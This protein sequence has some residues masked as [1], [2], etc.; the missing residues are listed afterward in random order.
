[1]AS[2]EMEAVRP[3]RSITRP[4]GCLKRLGTSGLKPLKRPILRAAFAPRGAE[5]DPP[6]TCPVA[7]PAG[8]QQQVTSRRTSRQLNSAWAQQENGSR[9]M[10]QRGVAVD[11]WCCST[12]QAPFSTDWS[13]GATAP[14]GLGEPQLGSSQTFITKTKRSARSKTERIKLISK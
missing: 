14:R 5:P 13:F 1:M 4:I 8:E 9:P 3:K 10:F 6:R 11:R 2:S 12:D 7:N